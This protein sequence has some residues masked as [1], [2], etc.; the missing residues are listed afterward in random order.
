[1]ASS[2]SVLVANA[3]LDWSPRIAALASA[4]EPLLA[5]DGGANHLARLGLRPSAVVGDLDS[6]KAKTRDWLGEGCMVHRPDQGRTDLDKAV[7]YAFD[8][9]DVTNLTVLAAL[10][11]R[12]DHEI[13][14]LGL[15]SRLATGE[16]LVFESDD[17]RVLAV[18][19]EA[20]LS[21][22]PG[23]TWS[24]WT[25]DPSVQ[26]RIGGVRWPVDGAALDPCKR[27]SI[28]NLAIAETV[29]IQSTGGAVVVC[30]QVKS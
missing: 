14:N 24:F 10:G 28:S 5:A 26:V 1:M 18:S 16:R 20:E 19:G 8:E 11:G 17:Q 29:S 22:C 15:L 6:I 30:R 4:G 12:T 27:P 23:E 21:A 3:P 13:G 9:L 2:G 25:F 7:E